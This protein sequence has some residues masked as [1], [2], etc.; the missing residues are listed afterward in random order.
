MIYKGTD[1]KFAI[2]IDSPG[3]NMDDDDF[4]IELINGRRRAIIDK[5]NMVHGQNPLISVRCLSTI[6]I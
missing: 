4:T 6:L 1:L 2:N 3:F 5:D